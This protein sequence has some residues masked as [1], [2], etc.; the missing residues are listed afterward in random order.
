MI[1]EKYPV[2]N[3]FRTPWEYA[4]ALI[5]AGAALCLMVFPSVFML[6]WPA[7]ALCVTALSLL[8]WRRWCEARYLSRFQRNLK[9]LPEYEMTSEEI[10]FKKERLFI[11]LGFY[12]TQE[13][14]QRLFMSRHPSNKH[15]KARNERYQ[16]V[17][18]RELAKPAALLSR[19]T[20]L[21]RWDIEH[22]TPLVSNRRWSIPP[23]ALRLGMHNP[24]APL[25]PV[26]GDP[27]IHGVELGERPI[28]MDLLERVGHTLVFGTT[29]V[30]KTR[31]CE[32]L[33][34]Q[35]IRRGEVVIVFDPKGDIQLCKRCFA[36]AKRAGREDN[37]WFF[38]LGFPELSD[39]YSPIGNFSRI[40]EVATRI[41][42]QLPSEG[43]SA[44]FRD[45]VWR[46]VNVMARAG[47]ALGDKMSYAWLYKNA[48]EVDSICR[49]YLEFWLDRDAPDW[50]NSFMPERYAEE[51]KALAKKT[52]RAPALLALGIHIGKLELND[53]IGVGVLSI[54]NNDRTYFEKLVSSLYPLLEKVTTG[55]ISELLSPFES[56]GA[57]KNKRRIFDWKTII[58]TGGIIYIGLDALSDF[59][60]SGAVGNAMFADLTSTA[61]RMYKFGGGYGQSVRAARKKINV[62]ADEMNELMGDEFIPLLNKGGGAD[63][64]VTAYTQTSADVEARLGNK[65]KADQAFGN[66]NTLIMLRVKN[67]ATAEILT[68]QLPMV[69]VVSSTLVSGSSD[70]GNPDDFADFGANT[71][72]RTST[73]AVPMLEPADLVS[74]PKGQAFALI[75]GG[76]LV[77]L[78][79][80]LPTNDALDPCWPS[81]MED[82]FHQMQAKYN[83]TQAT[84]LT[85]EGLAHGR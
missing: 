31:L 57:G 63:F 11:G 45:F 7:L 76:Q 46:F 35:D 53:G 34:A 26:G 22:L 23:W 85:V 40:T 36:E 50:R 73:R 49:R 79:L 80:P 14:V 81:S 37:F 83:S 64:Q 78:R 33:V 29:R 52:N 17:R 25:P 6:P 61:G 48:V 60:V 68:N 32:I 38:H 44:A 84:V 70:I 16:R 51:V 77:K 30:G 4:S 74:L 62:H 15:L 71:Q 2:E 21:K 69:E 12:W 66:F 72:D 41:A 1:F 10:P 56:S 43:Q 82:I 28:W 54:L 18:D 3:L 8:A 24:V 55:D 58:D 5:C 67:I 13:H 65:P 75:E 59:E 9:R 19:L 39:M 27:A 42:N 47:N 20:A